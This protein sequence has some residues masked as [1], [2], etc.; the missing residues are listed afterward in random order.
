MFV[1][2]FEN[3]AKLKTSYDLTHGKQYKQHSYKYSKNILNTQLLVYSNT[4][5]KYVKH[6]FWK[7]C[8]RVYYIL[9]F[10]CISLESERICNSVIR[11]FFLVKKN[12][13]YAYSHLCNLFFNSFPKNVIP[14][15]YMKLILK[16]FAFCIFFFL[17]LFR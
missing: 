4:F 7:Y 8:I 5:S 1:N 17:F 13:K 11:F 6:V 2:Y 16:H 12:L 3:G 9:Q 10:N 15:Y 14:I